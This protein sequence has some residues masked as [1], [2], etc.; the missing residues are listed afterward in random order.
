MKKAVYQRVALAGPA[1]VLGA[2]ASAISA[3]YAPQVFAAEARQMDEIIVTARR[4][5]EMA[6]EVP[7]S[8]TVMT[9]DFLRTNNV[10]K[11]EDIGTKVPS[12]RITSVGTSRNE[13]VVTLRGQRQGEAAFNQDPAA[14][15]YFNE[16][17]MAPIQGGN[18]GIYDLESLQV[19]KGP[20]GTLFGRN[21]TGG[22][23]MM[24]P[25]RPGYKLGGYAEVKVGNYDLYGFEGAVDVPVLDSLTT[26]L[27]V[28]KL[29]RDGYQKNIANNALYGKRYN[30]EHSEGA[31]F[32][33]NFEKDAF[34]N[35]TVISYEAGH[36]AAGVPVVAAI[37]KTAG[38]T[39]AVPAWS[40]AVNE[41]IARDNPWKVKSDIDGEENIRSTFFSNTTEYE[42]VEDLSVKNVFGYRKVH[43]ASA[44][45]ADGTAVPVFGAVPFGGA[46]GTL[47]PVLGKIDTEFYSNELQLFGAAF[48][49]KL[50]WITGLYWSKLGGA[51]HKLN[52]TNPLSPTGGY[53]NAHNSIENLS[54]GLFAEGT[55]EF[56]DELSLTVGAR[57]SLEKREMTV[58]KWN[59]LTSNGAA[60]APGTNYG[61]AIFAEGVIPTVN[62]INAGLPANGT[63]APD[64][65]RTVDEDWDSTTWKVSVNYTPTTKLL[66]YGS[67]STGFRA[68]G[69]NTR[70]D[71]DS[72][73]QPFDPEN[74]T[75]YEIGTKQD[76]E[77]AEM[78]LRSNLAVY[79]QQYEDIQQTVS[80]TGASGA[81]ETNTINAAKAEIK[82]LELDLSIKPINELTLAVSYSYV[83][84]KYKDRT[85]NIDFNGN[86]TLQA[87]EIGV[88]T[89]NNA[90]A[91]I[92]EQ[93][94]TASV[95][96]MLPLDASLGDISVM[97]SAYW[98]DEMT[99]HPLLKQFD[100]FTSWNSVPGTTQ[101]MKDASV[102]DSYTVYN[103]RVDW[104]GIMGSTFDAAVYVDNVTDEEYVQGGLNVVESLG[105][106]AYNYGA[107]RTFGASVK[108][109][110]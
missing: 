58:R 21:S 14:P 99:T 101:A 64:C 25:K 70:G 65:A 73:L 60:I 63:R 52:Q 91:Y 86:R 98:Q 22:A 55:Y 26:R 30:D 9:E 38:F 103:L 4:K 46:A 57:Q 105:L 12:L 18:A 106:A 33:V 10:A 56:F 39:P 82:G 93:S 84:A 107:P 68:G 8:M 62:L 72:T 28:H 74:V 96:Y 44:T 49:T 79:L 35:L 2:L 23:I 66:V 75:T 7:I 51:E 100:S 45:D 47:D 67:V 108:Y 17:V 27:A 85:D 15:L 24:T 20:Q 78:P 87:N 16:I 77:I 41:Q 40:A 53:E 76:W 95:T 109:S 81:L 94:A 97:A 110:F 88:D 69:F 42:I 71:Q 11:I 34:S 43:F 29:D 3:C 89:S 31:R 54:Y 6:Q 37:N 92:P 5:D 1:T 48:D 50:D 61:C 13:P 59:T 104:R 36:D 90:F 83:D 19:L 32:S 80:N 102:V